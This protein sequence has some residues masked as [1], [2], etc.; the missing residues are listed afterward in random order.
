MF[1]RGFYILMG[2][3]IILIA[4]T[5]FQTSGMLSYQALNTLF[6]IVGFITFIG[7]VVILIS[8]VEWWW[9]DA[10]RDG[11]LTDSLL[12]VAGS[13]ILIPLWFL[14][15]F[16]NVLGGMVWMACDV[17]QISD[18]Y[19]F[20]SPC[21]DF[22]HRCIVEC[23]RYGLTFTG[24]TDGCSCDCGTGWVSSCSGFY[25][26]KDPEG[27]DL[28]RITGDEIV[29]YP[30]G[31]VEPAGYESGIYAYNKS[32]SMVIDEEHKIGEV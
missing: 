14:V 25:Y 6:G 12:C 24:V 21:F 30:N 27:Q 19:F 10:K 5:S 9:A 16:P 8:I 1:G 23:E 22:H 4:F 26:D 2:L 29:E 17:A 15:L 11:K 20:D 7:F 31:T 32:E 28:I 3:V 13:I 18:K